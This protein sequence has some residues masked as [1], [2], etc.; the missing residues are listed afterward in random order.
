MDLVREFLGEPL[1]LGEAAAAVQAPCDPDVLRALWLSADRKGGYSRVLSRAE[2]LLKRYDPAFEELGERASEDDSLPGAVA[3][4]GRPRA[5]RFHLLEVGT[6]IGL[7]SESSG[8]WAG[9]LGP[10]SPSKL[11]LSM[12]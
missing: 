3:S 11:P 7:I 10:H 9:S 4:V 12:I 8:V 1:D 6:C 5:L 2:A